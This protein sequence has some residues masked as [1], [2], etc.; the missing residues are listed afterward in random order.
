MENENS[1][2]HISKVVSGL[3][4]T[5]T[6]VVVVFIFIFQLIDPAPNPNDEFFKDV[7]KVILYAFVGF[8]VG[9]KVS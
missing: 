4:V 6:I 2:M 8:L 9:K 3:L 7:L 5:I 1:W